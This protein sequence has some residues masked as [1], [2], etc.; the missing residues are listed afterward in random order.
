MADALE[1][2][3]EWS[4]PLLKRMEPAGR[5]AAML[6][7]AI[8]LRKSQAQRIADQRNPDG[9]PYEPRR[10][11]EQ[12][13][14]RQGAIRG[15]MFMGLRKARNL[16]RKATA[17]MAS[18]AMNPRVSYVARVHHYGL[19]DKVDRRDRNSPVVKYASREL[20]GYTQQEIKDIEDIL[21]EHATKG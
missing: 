10:P 4:T 8:Y 16:Q 15:Q 2:L 11:R 3:A 17:D 7:V 6:E 1:Q 18:V 9:S 5:K 21:L 20:L 14:K 13:T 19:R 12:L